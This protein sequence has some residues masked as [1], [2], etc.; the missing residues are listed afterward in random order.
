MNH[1]VNVLKEVWVDTKELKVWTSKA[2]ALAN[3]ALKEQKK[4]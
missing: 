2:E 3:E 4:A 1:F